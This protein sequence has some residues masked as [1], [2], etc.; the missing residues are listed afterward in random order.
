MVLMLVLEAKTTA[1]EGKDPDLSRSLAGTNPR[2]RVLRA[3]TMETPTAVKLTTNSK[4]SFTNNFWMELVPSS[5]TIM[6]VDQPHSL[7]SCVETRL[8][9][10]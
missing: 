2:T 8:F 6:L 10:K 4:R 5:K 1:R 9:I 3:T 7:P